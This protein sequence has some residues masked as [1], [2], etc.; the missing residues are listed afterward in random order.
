MRGIR[1]L[2]NKLEGLIEA[3]NRY[4]LT[5]GFILAIAILNAISINHT[6]E[7]HEKYIFTFI[8]GA[9]LST[10]AQQTFE[11][12]YEKLYE[13]LLLMVG[14]ALLT[15]IYFFIIKSA[16]NFTVEIIA[17]TAVAMFALFLAFI[18]VPTIKSKVTFNGSFMS[19]FK[20]AFLTILFT[21]VI[22]GGI[23]AIVLTIDNLLIP[24]DMTAL[25]H[26]LNIVFSLFAPIFFLSFTPFYLGAKDAKKANEAVSTREEY[27]MRAISCPKNLGILI[28]YIIIPLTAIY[29]IIL[30]LYVLLNIRGSFWSE[31]LLEPLLVS[32]AIT[33]ILV[34]ILASEL[35]NKF[36]HL[37][38]KVFP[39]VLVPI[40]LFQTIASFLKINEMGVTHGRYYVIMFGV[41]AIIAGLLFSFF[42]PNKNGLIAP[43]LI[44]FSVISIVPPVDAFTVSRVNQ[45]NLLE[46]TLVKNNMLNDH[47]IIPNGN[48]STED[49]KMITK[50]VSYLNRMNYVDKIEWLPKQ[51]YYFDNFKKTFGFNEVYDYSTGDNIQSLYA[52]LDWNQQPSLNI[53]GYDLMLQ[54]HINS[55]EGKNSSPAAVP[56]EKDGK[57]FTLTKQFNGELYT[58]IL[59]SDK[60]QEMIQVN[61]Q[62]IFEHIFGD[63]LDGEGRKGSILT[64]DQ[65]TITK[66]NDTAKLGVL[67]T[68]AN[69]T[70]TDF[71]Y[72]LYL[73]I[74]IK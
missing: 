41:F 42:P 30:L 25:P 57:R 27:I 14:A 59:N 3:I 52:S 71:N 72:D 31:N 2:R 66:E 54:M 24:L 68:S 13:R 40:V 11:R 44:I 23:S 51:I 7:N 60:S 48:I 49:K 10:V 53:S 34:Y 17:K 15:A 62:E 63:T 45:I 61:T 16:P 58:L 33:V 5:I 20:S 19:T 35:D 6:L 47:T 22:A 4:P 1:G 43:I 36:A 18:W 56:L 32:Y 39:K 64:M 9:L 8:I 38:R 55:Y 73:F 28:S 21:L 12:F 74:K 37:F 65:A 69:V 50:T 67:I 29:T 26:L 70:G 46:N